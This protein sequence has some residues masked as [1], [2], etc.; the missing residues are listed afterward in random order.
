MINTLFPFV[1]VC[2]IVWVVYRTLSR[3]RYSDFMIRFVVAMTILAL[4]I[5]G[6]SR[7]FS[8]AHRHLADWVGGRR[9]GNEP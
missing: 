6:V 2:A 1:A 3:H 8:G 4:G 7:L 9:C 5:P